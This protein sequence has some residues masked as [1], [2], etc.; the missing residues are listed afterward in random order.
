MPISIF[1]MSLADFLIKDTETQVWEGRAG[2]DMG[3]VLVP[4]CH[5]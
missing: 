5:P 2:G 4:V 1:I 3:G